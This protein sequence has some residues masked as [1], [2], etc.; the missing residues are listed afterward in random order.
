MAKDLDE[1]EMSLEEAAQRLEALAAELRD[2]DTFD[3]DIENRTVHLS[4]PSTIA[5]EVG[6]RETSSLLRGARE[7]VTV[8]MD[9]KPQS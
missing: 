8:K 9:W 7:T 1:N 6:V 4:P 2:E 3:I 5:M